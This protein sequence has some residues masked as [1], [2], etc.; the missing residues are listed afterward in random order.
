VYDPLLPVEPLRFAGRI[1]GWNGQS[2]LSIED[3]IIGRCR[4]L[5]KRRDQG[6]RRILD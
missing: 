5:V 3:K 1:S 6:T 2:V 4:R